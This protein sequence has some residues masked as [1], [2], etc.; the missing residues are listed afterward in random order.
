[1]RAGAAEVVRP[2]PARNASWRIAAS[3]ACTPRPSRKRTS[4]FEGWTLTST[5]RRIHF[6]EQKADRMLAAAEGV[7]IGGAEGVRERGVF[8][9]PAIDENQHQ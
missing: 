8:D 1:M 5:A 7:A 6:H 2:V 9:R 4:R 3:D